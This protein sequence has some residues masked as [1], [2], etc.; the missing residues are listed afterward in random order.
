MLNVRGQQQHITKYYEMN[1]FTV[2]I[3]LIYRPRG[4]ILKASVPGITCTRKLKKK[5][6]LGHPIT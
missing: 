2:V 3:G 6:L 4:Q 5:T 1:F